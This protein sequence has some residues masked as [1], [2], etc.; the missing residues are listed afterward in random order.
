VTLHIAKAVAVTV[1]TLGAVITRP[2]GLDEGIAAL[3]GGLLALVLGLVPPGEALRVELDSWNVFLF[4]LG[5]MAFAGLADQSGV[6]DWIAQVA[7]RLARGRVRVLYLLLFLIGATIT[8]LFANDSA[9]LVLTPIVYAL[10]MRLALDPLPFVFATTFI[11]DTASIALPVSNPLN[12]IMADR[13]SIG[14][15]SYLSHMWLPTL[16][17]VAINLAVFLLLFRRSIAGRF[18]APALSARPLPAG[19]VAIFIALALAYLVASAYRFPLGIVA[20]AGAAMLAAE[21]TR[22]RELDLAR[23]GREV[24]WSIFGFLAGLLLIVQGLT[25]SGVTRDLGRA[26]VDA[27]GTSPTAAIA[28]SAA[29]SA[30]GANVINNLPMALVMASAIHGL[31]ASASIRLDLV[32]GTIVGCDLGPN[33]THLG[34][35]ATLIWLLFLRRK[36]MDV[37]AWDYF[38]IG[39]VVMPLMLGGAILGLWLAS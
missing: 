30:L 34:S 21:L 39:V 18:A 27:V 37:S 10:V 15:A 29:G 5:M 33:L 6:F 4:F 17:A 31:H 35:L 3:V 7:G 20:C 11:A 2:R 8:V 13:F 25:D 19:T 24:S 9:A 12:V 38:R 16:L 26:L 22:R 1:I 28:V 32:Y 36:G 23:L 14:L